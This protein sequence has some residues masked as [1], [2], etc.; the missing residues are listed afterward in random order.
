MSLTVLIIYKS[1]SEK[2][3]LLFEM[4]VK[5]NIRLG[6]PSVSNEAIETALRQANAYDFVQKLPEGIDQGSKFGLIL[7]KA[8][9]LA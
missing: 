4:S 7:L 6:E 1:T 9:N 8:C 5:E 3:P 2:E